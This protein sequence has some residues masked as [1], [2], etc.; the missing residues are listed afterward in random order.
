MSEASNNATV[1]AAREAALG[2]PVEPKKH[3]QHHV[4][5]QYLKAWSSGGQIYCLR[6]GGVRPHGTTVVA[7]ERD[8]YKL[9]RLSARD[10]ALIKWLVIDPANP[11]AK[12]S[13]T[14]FLAELT[15][16]LQ[17]EGKS[18]KL[19]E[20]LETYRVNAIEDYHAGIEGSFLPLLKRLLEQDVS[21]YSAAEQ[22]MTLLHF[23]CT[24]YMRTK[25]VKARTVDIVKRNNNQDLTRI[26]DIMSHMFAVNIAA[27]LVMDGDRRKLTL[28]ENATSV[29]FVTGDQ[30]VVNLHMRSP[31][32]VTLL[33]L[34]YPV[35]PR[36]ALFLPE[37]DEPSSFSNNT[38]TAEQVQGLNR[39]MAAAS[40]SQV[41][42]DSEQVLRDIRDD[43]EE[44][45]QS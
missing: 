19:D 17:F 45:S 3:R 18:P 9:N 32:A 36:L 23:I 11:M 8:F 29:S 34:Y 5:Q 14:K 41:F 26:W 24:Q 2:L 43:A 6:D 30:P 25:G 42:G 39:K 22:R 37:V 44:I 31:Q 10:M 7:V 4:W 33:S 13:H 12:E 40:H 16:P 27:S 1:E 21:F 38:L 35:S 20:W 28:I 15:F